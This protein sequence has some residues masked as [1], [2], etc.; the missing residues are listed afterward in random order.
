MVPGAGSPPGS[1]GSPC[2]RRRSLCPT[3]CRVRRRASA[4]AHPGRGC[5]IRPAATRTSATSRTR[6]SRGSSSSAGSGGTAGSPSG[7]RTSSRGRRTGATDR[8]RRSFR[9]TSSS[10]SCRCG[11][12]SCFSPGCGWRSAAAGR[13]SSP[14][15]SV[16]GGVRRRLP[17]WSFLSPGCPRV[18]SSS[19]WATPSCSCR[20]RCSPPSGSP[21]GTAAGV[22]SRW[23]PG[24]CSSP[25]IRR[26]RSSRGCSPRST[27]SG[28]A[29]SRGRPP[30]PGPS[31]SGVGRQGR[32]S[33]RSPSCPSSSPCARAA[34]GSC[35]SPRRRRGSAP[36]SSSGRVSC[37]PTGW[38]T[39]G[40]GPGGGRTT[41]SRPG[42]T[43][44]RSRSCSR[45]PRSPWHGATGG[46]GRSRSSG[47]RRWRGRI[48][49]RARGS[50]S[51][52]CRSSAAG[53]ITT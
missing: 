27:C 12:G 26:R 24:S 11:S 33:Q 36:C 5:S 42:S 30:A 40:W 19:R 34:S 46:S 3:A 7:T 8:G 22:R 28:V 49:C 44:G 43:W 21:R 29:S 13:T 10:P 1:R 23:W 52:P 35:G 14:A 53:S 15:P 39:P 20:G 37:F 16:P 45:S 18:S 4:R 47:W 51:S 41:T 6:S 2:S 31:S 48:T 25:G 50:S 17:R 32:C 38:E 9:S